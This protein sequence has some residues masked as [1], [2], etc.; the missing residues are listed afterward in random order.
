M[1]VKTVFM[2][3]S[4][5]VAAIAALLACASVVFAQGP[6][7]FDWAPAN[8]ETVQLDPANYYGGRTYHP[9]SDGGNLHV[10][11]T[12]QKPVTVFMADAAEW[13]AALQRPDVLATVHELCPRTHVTQTTYTCFIPGQPMTLVIQ[14]ERPSTGKTVIAGISAALAADSRVGYVAR[15]GLASLL[16]GGTTAK[17]QLTSPNSIQIQ[18][19]RWT[20][21]ADCLQPRF[22]WIRQVREEYKLSP[23][24][25]IYGGFTPDSDG[26][27]VSI[28]VK[29]SVPLLV[30]LLPSNVADRLHENRAALE[31]AL[32]KAACQ[33]R[34][35]QKL[36]F[37]CT[38][39]I[40]DGPQS[41][42][43]VPEDQSRV[44]HK[45]VKIDWFADECVANCAP[46][47]PPAPANR[48][49]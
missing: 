2:R 47:P 27:E 3:K 28:I 18:Y 41:L 49:P 29:S 38:V 32:E 16:A 23:F 14:D 42:V 43:V 46:P 19:Y 44:P 10:D 36:Q 33:Q 48:N 24:M 4:A 40:S 22:E 31:G 12:S 13:S 21:V 6:R 30:A 20:C 15:V 25:K 9:G 11:I 5:L 17:K 1:V 8:R 26:E 37:Q 45:K 35:V 34:A 7:K 39:N